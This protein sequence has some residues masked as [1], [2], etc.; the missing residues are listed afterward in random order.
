MHA[1]VTFRKSMPL[2]GINEKGHETFFDTSPEFS[3]KGSAAS[4]MD[5]VLEA[6]GACSMMD[7]LSILKKMKR[8]PQLLEV[9]LDAERAED[10]PKVL[11]SIRMTYCLECPG[12]KPEELEKAVRLSMDKYCSVAA[13]LKASGCRITWLAELA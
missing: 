2:S 1:T 3:G 12:C 9:S 10:H 7:V 8:E 4:P 6:L 5:T 11:T 13:M